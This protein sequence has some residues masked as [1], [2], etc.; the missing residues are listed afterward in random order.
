[1]HITISEQLKNKLDKFI[2]KTDII[3]DPEY[4]TDIH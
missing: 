2:T 4:L 3:G 1:M